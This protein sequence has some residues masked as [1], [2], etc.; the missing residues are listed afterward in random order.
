MVKALMDFSRVSHETL[1]DNPD[2][3]RIFLDS[4]VDHRLLST[5]IDT[6]PSV[7][8][9]R[10]KP[11]R[12]TSF[13]VKIAHALE[14][15]HP[16]AFQF[17]YFDLGG[18]RVARCQKTTILIDSV[19]DE[20]AKLMPPT[21]STDSSDWRDCWRRGRYK[22][23]PDGSSIFEGNEPDENGVLPRRQ[24][25]PIEDVEALSKCLYEVALY[26]SLVCTFRTVQD[27]RP[28]YLGIIRWNLA[29]RRIELVPDMEERHSFYRIAFGGGNA[30]TL[31][32]CMDNFM[33]FVIRYGV[34]LE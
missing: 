25:D 20:G 22:C 18:H 5:I 12:C 1:L 11:G 23:H 13:A 14:K 9:W 30:A 32:E 24:S 15:K 29:Q 4:D 31:R 7:A 8:S 10:E 28:G 27:G 16:T 26:R 33:E 2:A 34:N 17:Q 6:H 19:S 21:T 3:L